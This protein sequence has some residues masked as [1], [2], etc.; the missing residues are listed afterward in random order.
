MEQVKKNLTILNKLKYLGLLLGAG[1]Y[2]YVEPRMGS[3]WASALCLLAGMG[4]TFICENSARTIMC[5]HVAK[6]LGAALRE[7]G[8]SRHSFEIKSLKTGLIIRIYMIRAEEKVAQCNSIIMERI[9]Q[10]WYK[11]SVWITQLVDLDSED[12][13]RDARESLD[14]EL[15]EQLKKMR[16]EARKK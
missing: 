10:S 2:L 12:D 15:V 5:E 6:D 16:D 4:F 8:F 7:R 3:L 13:I 14:D 1:M 9:S 11:E